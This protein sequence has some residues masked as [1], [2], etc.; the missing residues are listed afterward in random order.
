V[1]AVVAFLRALD[2]EGEAES[3]PAAFPR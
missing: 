2:G 3:A 1:R